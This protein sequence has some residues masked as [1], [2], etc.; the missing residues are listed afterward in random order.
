MKVLHD[1]LD[2]L[3]AELRARQV[4]A[5][6]VSRTVHSETGQRTGAIPYLTCRVIVTAALDEHLW[7]EWR[8]WVGRSIAEVGERGLLLP[9][10]LRKRSATA[11]TEVRCQLE[12]AGFRVLDG[13]LTHDAATMDSFRP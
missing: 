10:S 13:V 11:L 2:A 9:E 1:S 3:L 6:R 7:T 4:E 12:D 8:L 5:V